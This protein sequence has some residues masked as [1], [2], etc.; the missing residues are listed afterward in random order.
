MNG[1]VEY[2]ARPPRPAWGIRP[3]PR[4]PVSLTQPIRT[5]PPPGRVTIPID[6][7]L[8]M[9]AKPLVIVGQAV[10]TGE[11]IAV[12]IG[13]SANLPGPQIHASISGV[14]T[15]IEPR[16]VPGRN[17]SDHL[18][19]IIDS[20]GKDRA[21]PGFDDPG[22]PMTMAPD[23][24]CRQISAAGIVGLGG[25]LYST[26]AKLRT[27]Q[28]IDTLILNGAECEPYI[29]CDEI[30]MRDHAASI[31]RGAQIM[32]R[33]L[34][35]PLAVI[36]VE[37]DMPEARVALYE[38]TEADG[39]DNIHV[40]VVTA[41]YPAGGER[42]LT[43]LLMNREVPEH[44]LPADIGIVCHNVG[45]AA[46]VADLFDRRRPL[47]S[48]IVTVTGRGV[49]NPGNI[50]ARIG[51]PIRELFAIGGG[52]HA[53]ISHVIVGGPMMGIALPDASW[54][55]TKA[56]NCVIVMQTGDV[57][58]VQ[59]EMPCI[60]CG[61]C[62]QVCPSR[63]LPQELLMACRQ[64][65]MGAL[66]EFGLN[67]CI[68]CGCCDYV[69]PSQIQLTSRFIAAKA[70]L[71]QH[72]RATRRAE[73]AKRRYTAREARLTAQR[74]TESAALEQQIAAPATTDSIEAIMERA[75]DKE[76]HE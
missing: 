63:L 2:N 49:E 30:L 67:A 57:S 47:I 1:I 44:G 55:V 18:C 73:H 17:G 37:T 25:A 29:T 68:E 41:K 35:A 39:C 21:Y 23:H 24:I 74:E 15:A 4:K 59:T 45:T 7:C 33:A 52:L 42:Q 34:D 19:V 8:G 71:R 13:S 20:D 50:E 28:P 27:E 65:D 61:E 69:C 12:A 3:Q 60:R 11:P 53:D 6:Q 40:A 58:P 32:L 51:T 9:A 38:A 76:R 54:P 5:M 70:A 46:A 43:E 31:L 26:A 16:A 75:R 14:V 64:H 22:D 10:L 72:C 66:Q 62:L 48:R 36:A 56:T